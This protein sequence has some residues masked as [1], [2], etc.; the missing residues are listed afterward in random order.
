MARSSDVLVYKGINFT[1]FKNKEQ[2]EQFILSDPYIGHPLVT[3]LNNKYYI[4][5]EGKHR[6]TIAKCLGL[7]KAKVVVVYPK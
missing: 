3:V 6:L 7:K 2:F 1:K 4:Q 5:G